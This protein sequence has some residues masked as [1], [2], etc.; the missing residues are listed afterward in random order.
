MSHLKSLVFFSGL[1]FLPL[2]V[3][4]SQQ[5]NVHNFRGIEADGAFEIT[6]NLNGK[7]GIV[8]DAP[9][10]QIFDQIDTVVG[11][12][13]VLHIHRTKNAQFSTN[14]PIKVF[15]NAFAL[16]SLEAGGSSTINVPQSLNQPNIQ[17]VGRGSTLM[18]LTV[19]AAVVRA[20]LGG[21]SIIEIG[22]KTGAADVIVQ[23]SS[24]FKGS[25][26]QAETAIFTVSNAGKA[27]ISVKSVLA[28]HVSGN[29]D[30]KIWFPR[31]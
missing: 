16:V 12:D 11:A 6:V 20:S 21:S 23:G 4:V 2:A 27:E 19:D 8:I 25:Q 31:F 1:V 29:G 30:F 17:L 15:V 5:R 7:E 24:I 28:G 18:T 13:Q 3:A 10:Q 26:L 14:D 22:G 9:D